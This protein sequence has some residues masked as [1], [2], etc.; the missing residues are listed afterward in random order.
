MLAAAASASAVVVDI[1]SKAAVVDDDNSNSDSNSDG[2]AVTATTV[3]VTVKAT[4]EQ[5]SMGTF[6]G[7]LFGGTHSW[8][9]YSNS[10]S[11]RNISIEQQGNVRGSA[12]WR[13]TFLGEKIDW[14]ASLSP[15]VVDGYFF[16]SRICSQKDHTISL[17]QCF[18]VL[19]LASDARQKWH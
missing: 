17:P 5:S 10:D 19:R 16:L 1:N 6:K 15:S 8:E 7:L 18:S 4:S 9:N 13:N 14:Y 12:L 3:T 11:N 2:K